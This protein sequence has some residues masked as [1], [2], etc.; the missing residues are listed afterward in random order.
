MKP[1][2]A[3]ILAADPGLAGRVEGATEEEIARLR[4]LQDSPLPD[5]Y[6]E[7]LRFCG[8]SYGPLAPVHVQEVQSGPG[9]SHREE[10]PLDLTVGT[11]FKAL[12]PTR[13][14]RAPRSPAPPGWIL[15]GYYRRMTGDGGTFILDAGDP[16]LRVVETCECCGPREPGVPLA[17]LVFGRA[18]PRLVRKALERKRG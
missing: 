10:I 17:E 14:G 1:L 12:A 15:V 6:V 18:Q 11:L 9:K 3:E 2:I 5:D 4:V 13:R 8:R 16:R 7:L